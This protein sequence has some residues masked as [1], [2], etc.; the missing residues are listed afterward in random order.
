MI[1]NLPFD[2]VTVLVVD[3]DNVARTLVVRIVE[4]M[5]GRALEAEDGSSALRIV[6]EQRP[7]VVVADLNMEPVDGLAFLGGMRNSMDVY[8]A[9]TPA[10]M[11]T[12]DADGT[13]MEKARKLGIDAYIVKPF[14]PVGFAER[15]RDTVTRHHAA[16]AAGQPRS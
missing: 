5:G 1:E 16:R 15:L 2:D 9:A 11:F 12:A 7:M 6:H 10:L 4:K 13:K 8:V 3:D 14:T